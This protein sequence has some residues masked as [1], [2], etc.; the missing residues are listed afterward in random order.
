MSSPDVFLLSDTSL[1]E[2]SMEARKEMREE[3]WQ[4]DGWAETVSKVDVSDC[5]CHSPI[6]TSTD[7]SVDENHGFL[8]SSAVAFQSTEMNQ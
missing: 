8:H 7:S 3:V 1:S 4:L 5:H 6:Y 2:R